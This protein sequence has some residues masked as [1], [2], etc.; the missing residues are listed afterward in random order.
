MGIDK[1]AVLV[2]YLYFEAYSVLYLIQWESG[3]VTGPK[4]NI[5]NARHSVEN[6]ADGAVPLFHS[7]EYST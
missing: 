3:T 7:I 6:P 1:N 2:R 5:R 4:L